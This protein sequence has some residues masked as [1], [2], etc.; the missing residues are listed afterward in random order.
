[1]N[2]YL[3]IVLLL[4]ALTVQ[5]PGFAN[6]EKGEA[7]DN[8]LRV[9]QFNTWSEGAVVENGRQA[10]MTMLETVNPD[11]VLFQEVRGQQ[12]IDEVIAYFKA[13]GI[14][15]YGHSLNISTAFLSKYPIQSVRSSDELGADSYAFVKAVVRIKDLDF[16][17]YSMHLD[18][19]H[20][21]YYNLRG[22][23]GHSDSRPYAVCEPEKDVKKLLAESDLSRRAEEVKAVIEDAKKEISKGRSV[24]LGGDFNEP[25]F[26]DWQKNTRKMRS[27]NG[28]VVDWT[29]SMMLYKAGF[30]DCYRSVYP[31]AVTH[32]GFT[33][34]AGNKAAKKEDLC[35]AT[36]VDDRERIDLTY[37]YPDRCI[38]LVD[39]FIVGPKEDFWDGKIQYEATSD[40]FVTPDGVWASD[41][42]AVLTVY[43]LNE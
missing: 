6:E 30:K 43:R 35:W 42:K 40:S 5:L 19:K 41:H 10:I 2:I 23:D 38:K 14:T 16:A 28:L 37:F 33:C 21:A 8:E 3:K 15:Y 20:L 25:S 11:V 17:F 31:D 1:M 13:K 26:L 7:A 27:H 9:L 34:N 29:C 24:I 39:A 36:G 12:F 4:A 18:W 22:F 32:P